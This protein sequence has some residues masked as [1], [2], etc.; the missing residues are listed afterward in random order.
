MTCIDDGA[1]L[2]GVDK[3]RCKEEGERRKEEHTRFVF[4]IAPIFSDVSEETKFMV[5]LIKLKA[6][7]RRLCAWLG[8]TEA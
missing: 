6:V 5:L 2:A 8:T 3:M 4:S 7:M 1:T